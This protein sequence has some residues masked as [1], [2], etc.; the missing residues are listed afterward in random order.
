MKKDKI[1]SKHAKYSSNY[2]H[3]SD[4]DNTENI[5]Y[6]QDSMSENSE[7]MQAYQQSQKKQQ[8][9]LSNVGKY[10]VNN[11]TY[12]PGYNQ[13]FGGNK[14]FG[15]GGGSQASSY[16]NNFYSSVG[17]KNNNKADPYSFNLGGQSQAKPS[18]DNYGS[19]NIDFNK[20]GKEMNSNN[21]TA[22]F[23]KGGTTFSVQKKEPETKLAA[24][25]KKDRFVDQLDD[26]LKDT[27]D[28]KDKS[29][30]E[31]EDNNDYNKYVLGG[32]DDNNV[33]KN[34]SINLSH[35][36]HDSESNRYD[37]SKSK[38]NMEEEHPSV[39]KTKSDVYDNFE[40][41]KD[42][43]DKSVK[44]S[45]SSIKLSELS[46]DDISKPENKNKSVSEIVHEKNPKSYSL[47]KTIKSESE[48]NNNNYSNDNFYKSEYDHKDSSINNKSKTESR[49]QL[50]MT[51][52]GINVNKAGAN[53][54]SKTLTDYKYFDEE[55]GKVDVSTPKNEVNNNMFTI[56]KNLLLSN[57][58][59]S[60]KENS[61][62]ALK[63]S[64]EVAERNYESNNYQ[65][66][67][68]KEVNISQEKDD[69]VS[70]GYTKSNYTKTI[71][72]DSKKNSSRE[73]TPTRNKE[74]IT[75]IKDEKSKE[76]DFLDKVYKIAN[77][78]ENHSSYVKH[79]QDVIKS[80][81]INPTVNKDND[82][83]AL[84]NIVLK[85]VA[86][87]GNQIQQIKQGQPNEIAIS[88]QQTSHQDKV[89]INS[90]P[91]QN[92]FVNL[93]KV[94]VDELEVYGRLS[95][96][97][98][99]Y[100]KLENALAE[101]SKRKDIFEIQNQKL[102]DQITELELKMKRL[103]RLEI[104][105]SELI[106]S[107]FESEMKYDEL[108]KELKDVIS[109]YELKYRMIEERIV[110]RENKNETK[111]ISEIERNF[112]TEIY[113]LRAL[114]E[115]KDNEI[116][117]ILRERNMFSEENNKLVVNQMSKL[118]N[119][120][121]MRELEYENFLLHERNNELLE[122][123]EKA[124]Q[125]KERL[126]R[127]NFEKELL[128]END[129]S[130][131]ETMSKFKQVK[132]FP[133]QSL[134][135]TEQNKDDKSPIINFTSKADKM[136]AGLSQ[137]VENFSIFDHLMVEREINSLESINKAL[138][139]EVKRLNNEVQS[140]K[141]IN[142][143]FNRSIKV[144]NNFTE[145]TIL[146]KSAEDQIKSLIQLMDQ[147][148]ITPSNFIE[149]FDKLCKES[150]GEIDSESFQKIFVNL[151]IPLNK[152]EI[153]EIFNNFYK[154]SDDTILFNDF[155]NS[156]K[157]KNPT[158]F[159]VQ[160]DPSY[161]KSLESKLLDYECKLKEYDSKLEVAQIKIETME[162][163][164]I[165]L[166]R[167]K[168]DRDKEC[169]DLIRGVEQEKNA[170]QK[171]LNEV[172][173]NNFLGKQTPKQKQQGGSQLDQSPINHE[174]AAYKAKVELLE[175]Q[176]SHEKSEVA[177]AQSST[178]YKLENA[179]L[180][181]EMKKKEEAQSFQNEV[182]ALKKS[183]ADLQLKLAELS[184]SY[185]N[186]LLKYR[187][188]YTTLK[189]KSDDTEKEKEKLSKFIKDPSSLHQEEVRLLERKI[190]LLEQNNRE[191]EDKY[192]QICMN[193]NANQ[194]N[195]ELETQAKKFDKERLELMNE[196]Q[197]KNN[198]L[199]FIKKEFEGIIKELEDLKLNKRVR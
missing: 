38:Y 51:K 150:D 165:R 16:S 119:S 185:E 151:Q 127:L 188:N 20:L 196:I 79:H 104:E 81:D 32:K 121:K 197:S 85:E 173:S 184:Q 54:K 33:V 72:G 30:T 107:K 179:L 171:M 70:K 167:E 101:T 160:S 155:I 58:D 142:K 195:R 9:A 175:Q 170:T 13:T 14:G 161:I 112:K 125:Q 178:E 95:M 84:M 123:L 80:Q 117:K 135:L 180:K 23:N 4:D 133:A 187:K 17:L 181:L 45:K 2:N 96:K 77:R 141:N 78:V 28:L 5:G 132:S 27:S 118:E 8:E 172:M 183:N 87:L 144:E 67:E 42:A 105:N 55:T 7:Y 168:S 153:K 22:G 163:E 88:P 34:K 89:T 46:R 50:S 139:Q 102:K 146:K 115:E 111:K 192:R 36:Y 169:L 62:N 26:V 131:K 76:M 176:L 29:V 24:K 94:R 11:P 147:K 10:N 35:S 71:S 162:E 97:D 194:V 157:S 82:T 12:K 6:T 198:E 148:G 21:S 59:I 164:L 149:A 40:Q 128:N 69:Y 19:I 158:N 91:Q 49:I 177:K 130:L 15:M 124:V 110:A 75:K 114:L 86:K 52:S 39:N 122:K 74:L 18:Y 143:Q 3:S 90:A 193:V 98:I 140:L 73:P 182:L 63:R 93:R 41:S 37:N 99:K 43:D 137:E 64:E 83:Q 120:D 189:L 113:N 190:E 31:S 174:L 145:K 191:R 44:S 116:E 138:Q 109:D 136:Y 48:E 108:E 126:D 57:S 1:F 106:K 134:Q 68:I 100:M 186:K 166:H 66:P 103:K 53:D 60:G 56:D 129:Q 92:Y 156:L 152:Y 61:F 154:L 47:D 25:P 159:Y 199:N 65:Q